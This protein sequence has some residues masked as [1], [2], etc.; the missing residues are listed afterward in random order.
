M[1]FR[2]GEPID[3]VMVVAD[4]TVAFI[5]TKP[6]LSN[7][8]R[9]VIVEHRW[10]GV[11]VYTLYAHLREVADGI[12]VG[13]AVR[14]GQRI[15]TMGRSTNTREG[16]S[17]DRA[18]VHFEINFLLNPNFRIWY[19]HRDPKAPP[20]GNF[21]GKNLM[22]LNAADF[23]RAYAANPKLNFLA[24]LSQQPVAFTVLVRADKLPWS[25]LHPELIVGGKLAPFYELGVTSWGMPVSMWPRASADRRVPGIRSVNEALLNADTCRHL[26]T[27]AGKGWRFTTAGEEW[28]E[29]MTFTP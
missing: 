26:V 2:S 11:P 22:G 8:G 16:I 13:Q 14:K 1:L 24:Y 5:N 15:A 28:L 9:Y 29:I 6:G 3:P 25:Q 21:N 7:Y 19:P 20:F 18:H 23:F 17:A 10:D 12:A 27:Q 4:G